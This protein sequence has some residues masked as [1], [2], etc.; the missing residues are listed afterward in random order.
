MFNQ[1][2]WIQ[3]TEQ[4]SNIKMT[5]NID[6]IVYIVEKGN[7]IDV[8]FLIYLLNETYNYANVKELYPSDGKGLKDLLKQLKSI[9]TDNF[10]KMKKYSFDSLLL[11]IS[12][13][14]E[15]LN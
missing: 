15:R 2:T 5:I 4:R 3:V 10:N 8:R 14:I 6:N 12:E 1:T 7:V 13:F 9:N 11:D